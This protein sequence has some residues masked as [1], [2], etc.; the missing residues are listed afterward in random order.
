MNPRDLQHVL[1]RRVT[2][3]GSTGSIG[4]S[5]LS[6]IEHLRKQF[7]DDA[8]PIESLTRAK[9]CRK[10]LAAQARQFRPRRAVIGDAS[11]T[12][13]SADLLAGTGIEVAAGTDSIVEAAAAPADVTMV[14]HR[15]RGRAGAGFRRRSPAAA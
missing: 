11:R 6:V 12:P 8:F 15:G 1:W 13:H 10:L 14:A 4:K 2:V 5:T 9:Q 3:L 7:D